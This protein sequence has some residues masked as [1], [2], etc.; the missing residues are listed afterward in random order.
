MRF[1]RLQSVIVAMALVLLAQ[2]AAATTSYSSPYTGIKVYGGLNQ[3]DMVFDETEWAS[4]DYASGGITAHY[5]EAYVKVTSGTINCDLGGAEGNSTSYDYYEAE[6]MTP[7]NTPQY[8]TIYFPSGT[9]DWIA[10][11]PNNYVNFTQ[12]FSW[13]PDPASQCDLDVQWQMGG[14]LG[15]LLDNG[16]SSWSHFNGYGS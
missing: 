2:P 11:S 1:K 14:I 5:T 12:Q 4:W 15:H 7:S 16:T 6:N 10:G 8:P 3:P 9:V 13:V